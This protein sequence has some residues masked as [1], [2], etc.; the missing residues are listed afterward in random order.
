MGHMISFTQHRHCSLSLDMGVL[1]LF[2]LQGFLLG[3]GSSSHLDGLGDGFLWKFA[4]IQTTSGDSFTG[5][6]IGVYDEVDFMWHPTKFSRVSI[7]TL[8]DATLPLSDFSVTPGDNPAI[9]DLSTATIETIFIEEQP[10][11]LVDYKFYMREHGHV[12]H[13]TPVEGEI[14]ISSAWD[15]Y[16]RWEDGRSNYAW[17]IGAL[18]NNMMSYNHYGTRNTDFEVF[19]KNVVLP[20]S[21]RVVTVISQEVDNDP[22]IDAAVE[23]EDKSSGSDIDLEEKPQ[24]MIEVE[25]GGE[26]SPF[27]LRLIH[28]KQ[29]SMDANIQ[30]GDALEA[31][32]T[33][34]QAG[35]SGTTYVPHCHAVFGFT[36]ETDRFWSLPVEWKS[37]SH[38]IL[39]PY[40]HGYQYG[41]SHHHDYLYP[42]KGYVVTN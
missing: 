3:K 37:V 17:D 7:F 6:I 39:L 42:L 32:T 24:N 25:I 2:F 30:V 12:F 8:S 33:V 10:E 27:L 9:F 20:M 36:D 23:I 4:N 13:N 38:R 31:G 40:P 14:W 21:G 5:Q 28:F 29:N 26:G 18:N 11:D 16:H 19:G 22:D 1:L 35:N 34:A 41:P 15:S